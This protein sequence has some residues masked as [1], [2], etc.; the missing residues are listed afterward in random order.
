MLYTVECSALHVYS[1][2]PSLYR[3]AGRTGKRSFSRKRRSVRQ[4][5]GHLHELFI[6]CT[7]PLTPPHTPSCVQQQGGSGVH[8][9][10]NHLVLH[11]ALQH[12]HVQ[13]HVGEEEHVH[14]EEEQKE[15]EEVEYEYEEEEEVEEEDVTTEVGV[16]EVC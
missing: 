5:F 10:H 1:M 6:Y 11:E 16:T 7:N 4:H 3:E 2:N 12:A 15:E 13:A 8:A 9:L 14:K